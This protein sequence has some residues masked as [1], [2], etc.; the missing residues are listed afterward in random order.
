MYEALRRESIAGLT[1]IG[2][3]GY[4]IGGLAVGEPK[5]ERERVLEAIE[6]DL[7]RDRPRY[8]MGVGTPEDLVE[9][10]RRGV[11]MFDC[12]MPTRHAR[13]GH[14]F[15]STGV[16]KIR[17]ARFEVDTGPLD[18]A[19]NCYTCANYTRSYLRHLDRC[20]EILAARLG[21]IHNLHY[22]LQ[23]MQSMREA[24]ESNRFEAFATAF[25]ASRASASTAAES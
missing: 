25:Y 22:Y 20:N 4:A 8:L 6:P 5:E 2:F 19:C 24:I 17:N 7:P 12:V 3:H 10:V 14:L 13:N 23:L 15:T 16:L 1:E 21:T 18:P 11:D 9:S